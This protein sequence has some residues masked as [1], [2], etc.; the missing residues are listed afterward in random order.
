MKKYFVLTLL[1][2]ILLS[3]EISFAQQDLDKIKSM[4]RE[5]LEPI[6]LDIALIKSQMAT[7]EELE[8][9]KLDIASIKS[10]MATKDDIIAMRE[11]F[12]EKIGEVN[13]TVNSRID[14]LYNISLAVWTAIFAAILAAIFG[15]PIFSKWLEKRS[16]SKDTINRM[17]EK[18]LKR[19]EKRPEL[20]EDYKAIGL[21]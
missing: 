3:S 11:E 19:V 21:L 8:P 18:A 20:A 17:R 15:G 16:Q 7:K 5:E 13:S 12:T 14:E 4:I 10:Q 6:K 1:F 9:L 2:F